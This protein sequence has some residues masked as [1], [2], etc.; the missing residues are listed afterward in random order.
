MVVV[1]VSDGGGASFCGDGAVK[2]SC[3]LASA[4]F[5][6]FCTARVSEGCDGEDH[7]A[8]V[9]AVVSNAGVSDGRGY[10]GW[11][12]SVGF[13]EYKVFAVGVVPMLGWVW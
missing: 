5:A 9:G 8:E 13:W 7:W 3:A 10:C 12:K 11:A 1:D 6:E 2:T 4:K